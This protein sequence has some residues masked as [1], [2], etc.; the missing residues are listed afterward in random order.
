MC[1]P[2]IINPTLPY[3][4]VMQCLLLKNQG[5]KI[6]KLSHCFWNKSPPNQEPQRRTIFLEHFQICH[7]WKTKISAPEP[8]LNTYRQPWKCHFNSNPKNRL[9]L[10]HRWNCQIKENGKSKWISKPEPILHQFWAE[11]V[12]DI[13]HG[14]T[15]PNQLPFWFWIPV[16]S[17][18]T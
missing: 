6:Y 2:A 3:A 17:S 4:P 5:G 12:L 15:D 13:M 14:Y 8:S 11:Q 10:E 16:L 7:F 18:A 1:H 9:C